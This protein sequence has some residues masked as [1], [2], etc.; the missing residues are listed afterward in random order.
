ME[1]ALTK[2]RQ[3]NDD[4]DK[5]VQEGDTALIMSPRSGHLAVARLLFEAGADKGKA[6]Q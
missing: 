5:A 2:T 3:Y 6:V 1:L 4:K